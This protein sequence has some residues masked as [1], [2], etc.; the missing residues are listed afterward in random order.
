MLLLVVLAI[1]ALILFSV[2]FVVH[3]LFII[4]AIVALIWLISLFTGGFGRSGARL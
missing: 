2:G 4:A 1:L 3:W